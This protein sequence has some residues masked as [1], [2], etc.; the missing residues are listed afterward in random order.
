MQYKEKTV[1]IRKSFH[2]MSVYIKCNTPRAY[3]TTAASGIPT[4]TASS[5]SVEQRQV[6]KVI[7][8]SP[9]DSK[10]NVNDVLNKRNIVSHLIELV[11]GL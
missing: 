2:E 6:V 11:V 5:S 10:I 3:G 9:F 1:H 8:L 4:K 7:S